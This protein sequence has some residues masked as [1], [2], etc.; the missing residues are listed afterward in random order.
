MFYSYIVAHYN[1]L[2]SHYI[3]DGPSN[4]P[5]ALCYIDICNYQTCLNIS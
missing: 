5:A 2:Y 3:V 1:I 4:K